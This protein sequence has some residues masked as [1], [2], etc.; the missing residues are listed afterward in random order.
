[1]ACIGGGG[2]GTAGRAPEICS[3]PKHFACSPRQSVRCVQCEQHLLGR[4]GGANFYKEERGLFATRWGVPWQNC[5]TRRN[6][7]LATWQHF[8]TVQGRSCAG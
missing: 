5:H 1:M 4:G 6:T 3:L 2:G 8:G 7:Q